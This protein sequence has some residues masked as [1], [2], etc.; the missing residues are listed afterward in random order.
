MS[1]AVVAMES[2][3]KGHGEFHCNLG[4]NWESGES[5]SQRRRFEVPSEQW[6]DEISAGEDVEAAGEDCTSDT[7]KT[8]QVPGYLGSVDAKMWRDRAVKTLF[9]EDAGWIS[10]IW[11]WC[12]S[13]CCWSVTI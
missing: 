1:H 2:E 13:G 6:G 10:G 12:R 9:C 3:R 4:S 11:C 8:G 5:S 7:V